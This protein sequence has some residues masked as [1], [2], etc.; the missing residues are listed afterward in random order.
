MTFND[1][2]DSIVLFLLFVKQLAHFRLKS[3]FVEN[4][5]ILITLDIF[6]THFYVEKKSVEFNKFLSI[7]KLFE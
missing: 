3:S 4:E 5:C 6:S 7:L 2:I 1:I